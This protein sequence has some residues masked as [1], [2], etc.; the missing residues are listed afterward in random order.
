MN[1]FRKLKGQ[2]APKPNPEPS[3]IVN[4][5]LMGAARVGKTSI[6]TRLLLDE[7]YPAYLPTI[8][9]GAYQLGHGV[10]RFE[11]WFGKKVIAFDFFD[12]P[13]FYQS[14]TMKNFL[15]N[16]ADIFIVVYAIDEYR[17]F[18]EVSIIL[19]D[20]YRQ[21]PD[22]SIMLVGNKADLNANR[23]VPYTEDVL[24]ENQKRLF[25]FETS[26]KADGKLHTTPLSK[27]LHSQEILEVSGLSSSFNLL[28]KIRRV[29]SR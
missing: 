21:R 5:V 6:L 3:Q 10:F 26:A 27:I 2:N 28:S 8:E 18:Q 24:Y 4:V 29:F 17:S 7:F 14:T 16:I 22:A 1:F 25:V 23:A 15:I 19:R 13:G 12:S 9:P 20:I 11:R